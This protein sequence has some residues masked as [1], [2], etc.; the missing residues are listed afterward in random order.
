MATLTASPAGTLTLAD[1]SHIAYAES[2]QQGRLER[3]MKFVQPMLTAYHQLQA[4]A[5][6]QAAS[7]AMINEVRKGTP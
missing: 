4:E 6:S 5:L 1:R 2:A 7:V 3:D